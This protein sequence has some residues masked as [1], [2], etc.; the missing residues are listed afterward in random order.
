M[1]KL[2]IK[3][4]LLLLSLIILDIIA[5]AIFNLLHENAI[6]GSTKK[7]FYILKE[8]DSDIIILGSSRASHHYVPDVIS[9]LTGYSCYNCGEEGNGIVLGYARYQMIVQRYNPKVIVYEITPEY[10]FKYDEDNSKYLR[11]LKPYYGEEKV[12]E[13]VDLFSDRKTQFELLSNMYRNNS[14]IIANI[15]D[16]IIN[17]G[18][19]NGYEPLWG[20]SVQNETKVH[21]SSQIVKDEKKIMLLNNM[22]KDAQKR[23]IMFMLVMSPSLGLIDSNTYK[24]AVCISNKYNIPFI[25]YLSCEEITS[26]LS[27]FQD[28]GHMNDE[29]ARRFS[30]IFSEELKRRLLK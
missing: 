9:G 18:D 15:A 6:G 16:N 7:N 19:N 2:F 17:R 28:E 29:G 24:E 12:K 1:K 20:Q 13:V 4:G 8:C 10:D 23:G 26:N 5:G 14:A 25:N 27:F 30:E 21:K 11:Y 22:V 3:L